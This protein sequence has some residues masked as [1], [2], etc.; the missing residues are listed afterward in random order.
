L[1]QNLRGEAVLETLEGWFSAKFS[2]DGLGHIQI[3]CRVEDSGGNYRG[4]YIQFMLEQDQ[5][6]LPP[7]IQNLNHLEILYPVIGK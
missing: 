1:Y 2:G 4:N 5:T 7:I 6:F 3:D